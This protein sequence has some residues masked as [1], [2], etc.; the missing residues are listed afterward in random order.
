M[1][2]ELFFKRFEK[3][4]SN[5]SIS[6]SFYEN[7]SFICYS[8]YHNAEIIFDISTD[9]KNNSIKINLACTDTDKVNEFVDCCESVIRIYSPDDNVQDIIDNLFEY[10]KI[11]NEFRYYDTRWHTYSST[12][13]DNGMY[14]SV[15]NKKLMP[16]SEV[17]F[18]LKQNDIVEY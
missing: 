3:Y 2:P 7:N 4:D 6:N 15:S 5:L 12:L 18:S 8:L 1:S 13:S 16:E 9:G 14:F 17:E 10:K 11:N